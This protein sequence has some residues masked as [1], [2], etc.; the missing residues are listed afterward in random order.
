MH[1]KLSKNVTVA[2]KRAFFLHTMPSHTHS[3]FIVCS[4]GLRIF[5]YFSAFTS[6][7]DKV[8]LHI[9]L[10]CKV[11]NLVGK[12]IAVQVA[13]VSSL[14]CPLFFYIVVHFH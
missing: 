8:R 4:H 6:H 1:F 11:I 7:F 13:F 14:V 10:V 9:T 3:F 12:V 2:F 5:K